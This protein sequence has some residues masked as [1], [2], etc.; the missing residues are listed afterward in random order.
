MTVTRRVDAA[1]MHENL[2]NICQYISSVSAGTLPAP[3]HQTKTFQQKSVLNDLESINFSKLLKALF[4][5]TTLQKNTS[6]GFGLQNVL[7]L[8]SLAVQTTKNS[9]F[10]DL[11]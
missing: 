11:S 10:Q 4:V 9:Q 5:K 1:N 2:T 6:W 7:G 3:L 8:L